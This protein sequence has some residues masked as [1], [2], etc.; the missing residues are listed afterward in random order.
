[1]P[2]IVICAGP[3]VVRS[4]EA[5]PVYRDGFARHVVATAEAGIVTAARVKARLVV[6][7]RDL[8]R[9]EV[10]VTQL[11]NRDET[12]QCAIAIVSPGEI[13]AEDLGLL[14]AGANAV[15]RLPPGPEWDSRIEELLDVRTRK[16]TRV[17]VSLVFEARYRTERVPG[18]VLNLSPTGMLV[19]CSAALSVGSQVSFSFELSGFETSTGEVEGRGRVVREAGPNRYAVL[20]TS[21]DEIGRELLRR[22]LLVP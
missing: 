20:F 8:P 2:D 16:E 6:I 12:R 11:R 18:R 13:S 5:S 14:S 17:P 15:L 1:M 3:N 19:E 9:A 10:L 21:I 22:F 7:E 4:L